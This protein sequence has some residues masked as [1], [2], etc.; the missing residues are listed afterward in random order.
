MVYERRK[1]SPVE[2]LEF[3]RLN[4]QRHD[5]TAQGLILSEEDVP[6]FKAM[7]ESYMDELDP[8]GI[9]QN[10]LVRE[11]VVGKWR[12]ERYWPIES[13]LFELALY[14]SEQA[15]KI[16]ATIEGPTQVAFALLKQHGH[17][18][19]IDL[20]SRLEA[21]MR[22]IHERARKDLEHLQAAAK[23]KPEKQK[24]TTEPTA[25]SPKS[26]IYTTEPKLEP[27]SVLKNQNYTYEPTAEPVSLQQEEPKEPK[28][29]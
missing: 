23:P 25:N 10:D 24:N 16:F 18:K 8:I 15:L 13:A 5:H 12:Q 28:A 9:E 21:R 20:V 14:S 7:F 11:I 22:K 3:T 17:A 19:A 29:A 2:S 6:L 4:Q 27:V 26:R 1:S